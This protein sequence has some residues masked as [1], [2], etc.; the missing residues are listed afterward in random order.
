MFLIK[1]TLG[2]GEVLSKKSSDKVYDWGGID[3][4]KAMQVKFEEKWS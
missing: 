4:A 1:D 3:Q 2:K